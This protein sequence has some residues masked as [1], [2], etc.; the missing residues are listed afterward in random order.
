LPSC[1]GGTLDLEQEPM[2]KMI[3]TIQE[4]V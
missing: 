2:M 3:K 1:V 4:I